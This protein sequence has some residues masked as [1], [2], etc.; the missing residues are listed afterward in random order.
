MRT[1]RRR[2]Y[3]AAARRNTADRPNCFTSSSASRRRR[4]GSSNR[5]CT[6]FM[7]VLYHHAVPAPAQPR[8]LH[9]PRLEFFT[10]LQRQGVPSRLLLFPDEGHWINKPQNSQVWYNELLGWLAQYLAPES[11]SQKSARR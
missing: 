2:R 11:G 9:P 6:D 7:L 5:T 1:R 10:A 4:S 8:V 3:S